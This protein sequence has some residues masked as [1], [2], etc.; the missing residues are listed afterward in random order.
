VYW[1]KFVFSICYDLYID[2]A[3]LDNF[4]SLYTAVG[5]TGLSDKTR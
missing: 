3:P 2:A 1:S 5:S 4:D